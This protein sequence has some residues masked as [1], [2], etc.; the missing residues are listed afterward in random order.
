[1]KDIKI[2][3]SEL[4]KLLQ[5]VDS[6]CDKNV[7]NYSLFG[8]TAIGA[9]RHHGFIP[10]DDDADIVM[11]RKNFQRFCSC[12]PDEYEII[13]NSWVPRFKKID[14]ELYI[15]LFVFDQTSNS[16]N[17]QKLQIL[18]LKFLQGALKDKPTL[19]KGSIVEKLLSLGTY[20]FGLPFSHQQKLKYY[21]KVAQSYKEKSTNF[22]FSSL[23]QFKYIQHI[24]PKN[25]IDNYKMTTFEDTELMIME[26]YDFYLTKFYGD[27]MQ[28]PPVEERIPEHGNVEI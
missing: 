15:D 28:L 11:T 10:W 21:D 27:Y 1:M 23:D 5:T 16:T 3:H 22:V 8:G 9:I 20:L 7:I 26:G 19:N 14:T 2:I 13:R 18:K 4:L 6:I 24:L 25:I 17:K 12:I